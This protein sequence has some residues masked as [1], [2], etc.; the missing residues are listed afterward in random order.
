[1]PVISGKNLQVPSWRIPAGIYVSINVDS[2]RR[3][4]SAISVLSS[5][6]S[7]A[8]GDIVTLPSN[9]SPAL[10]IDISAS[11]KLGRVLGGGEVIGK[12]QMSWDEL[13]D[14]GDHPFDLSFRA[15]HGVKP[16]ITRK[17]AVVYPC[18]DK[19]G[20]PFD[21]SNPRLCPSLV[22]C[23]ITR[24]TDVGHVRL[25]RYVRRKKVSYLND[26]VEHFQL[27]LNQ[28]RVGHPDRATALTNL[29]W[30][31][32]Q[33]YIRN[34]VQDIDTITSLFRD[35]LA[36]R[37]QHHPDHPLSLYNLTKALTWRHI[38][39]STDVDICEA[40]Q[41]YYELL[42]LCP[43]GTYLCS[44]A[45]GENGVDSSVPQSIRVQAACVL[46]EIL[47]VRRRVRVLDVLFKQIVPA[48]SDVPAMITNVE[49]RRLR[50]TH[51]SS[52][53]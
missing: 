2:R 13:L 34:V 43:E 37:P 4:K 6:E 10:S 29:A 20:A 28:C 50:P 23:E 24:D 18:D 1:M 39:K 42:P 36:L 14:H 33:G 30:V 22:D 51:D 40:V 26:A 48:S 11:Y 17:V 12:L 41:L 44:I 5:D 53:F 35:A 45:A 7:V 3:W 25:P 16:S 19:N 15:V 52:S 47:T 27:V 46:D 9:A 31:R 32:L 49:L 38:R 21:A 8:W